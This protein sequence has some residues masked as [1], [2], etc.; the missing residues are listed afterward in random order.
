MAAPVAAS[1]GVAAALPGWAAASTILVNLGILGASANAEAEEGAE[2]EDAEEEYAEEEYAEGEDDSVDQLDAKPRLSKRQCSHFDNVNMRSNGRYLRNG[3]CAYDQGTLINSGNYPE[4]KML[5]RQIRQHRDKDEGMAP[6]Q[7]SARLARY[8]S[9][10][11][12]GPLMQKLSG[13]EVQPPSLAPA[14]LVYAV[15]SAGETPQSLMNSSPATTSNS[16]LK[17][18]SLISDGNPESTYVAAA[19]TAIPSTSSV[20]GLQT[21]SS[22]FCEGIALGAPIILVAVLCRIFILKRAN[23]QSR[24]ARIEHE[25]VGPY[26]SPGVKTESDLESGSI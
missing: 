24:A 4:D 7:S 6:F 25:L 26:P 15:D 18:T 3:K 11:T 9:E 12:L 1:A 13:H 23:K 22:G 8:F 20:E 19:P 16:T 17:L 14:S 10:S 21:F 5:P 2:E